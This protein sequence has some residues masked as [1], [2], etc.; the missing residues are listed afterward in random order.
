M[1]QEMRT[2]TYRD[3]DDYRRMR[4]LLLEIYRLTGKNVAWDVVRLDSYRYGRYWQGERDNDRPWMVDMGLWETDAGKLVAIAHPEGDD[5]WFL[6]MHPDFRHLA[7]QLLDWIE[8][9]HRARRPSPS[10]DWPLN[11]IFHEDLAGLAGLA[12]RTWFCGQGS[13]RRDAHA[14]AGWPGDRRA[15]WRR[16]MRYGRSTSPTPPTG[17]SAPT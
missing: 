4:A 5:E 9:R 8:Q 7:P 1:T 3:D 12:G 16:G 17:S 15:N 6:D 13:G 11:I 14:S 10:A 2:R